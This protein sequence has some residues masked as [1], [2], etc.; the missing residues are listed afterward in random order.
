MFWVATSRLD[1]TFCKDSS[2][3]KTV[4]LIFVMK[5]ARGMISFS[6]S[7]WRHLAMLAFKLSIIK[8][9]SLRTANAEGSLVGKVE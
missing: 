9:S 6:F 2:L 3:D 7:S 8:R 5:L 4:V 1:S